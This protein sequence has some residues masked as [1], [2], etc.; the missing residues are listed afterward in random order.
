MGRDVLNEFVANKS[1][2]KTIQLCLCTLGNGGT[3]IITS[4]L[5]SCTNLDSIFLLGC[6]V[7]DDII[8]D[9]VAGIRG[10]HRLRILGFTEL[11]NNNFG[12]FGRVGFEALAKLLRDP[13]GNLCHLHFNGNNRIDDD[14]AIILANALKGNNKLESLDLSRNNTITGR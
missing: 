4:A 11:G 13:N 1:N 12:N 9:F 2:L 5:R 14:C 3:G 7:D 8:V 6:D 10:L